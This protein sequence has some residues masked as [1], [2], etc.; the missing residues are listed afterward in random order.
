MDR[1][2]YLTRDDLEHSGFMKQ[3]DCFIARESTIVAITGMKSDIK[4]IRKGQKRVERKV[5]KLA[6]AIHGTLV[7]E[8]AKKMIFS[9]LRTGWKSAPMSLKVIIYLLLGALGIIGGGTFVS[10]WVV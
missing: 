9:F 2:D 7:K 3:K 4:Y 10:A 1:P 8:E 6:D 5:D